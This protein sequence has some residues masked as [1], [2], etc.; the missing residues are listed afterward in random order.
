MYRILGI[1]SFV[2]G[3]VYFQFFWY[4][5]ENVAK[6]VKPVPISHSK[7]KKKHDDLLFRGDLQRT[8]FK[9]TR[10]NQRQLR[11]KYDSRNKHAGRKTPPSPYERTLSGKRRGLG[12]QTKPVLTDYELPSDFFS[13]YTVA[14]LEQTAMHYAVS[15]G[16]C[17][18]IG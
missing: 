8:E 2:L 12:G 15:G 13:E 14:E 16:N 17:S 18:Y 7:L 4:L 1:L 9:A 11:Q 5:P 10:M 6:K 3:R